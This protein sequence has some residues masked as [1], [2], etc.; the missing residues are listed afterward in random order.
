MSDN[1]ISLNKFISSTGFCSRRQAD[2]WI[3]SGRVRING[4]VAKK[5]NRVDIDDKV[6]I[7][8]EKIG[9]TKKGK[10]KKRVYI[11]LNK[12]KGITCTTDLKDKDNIISYIRHPKR[13][14]PIGRLDK[15]STGL[16]LLTNDGD[17][18]NKILRSENNHEKEYEVAVNKNVT[19]EFLTKMSSGVRIMGKRTKKCKV[20]KKGSKTFTITLTEG[21]N[22]QIRRMCNAFDYKVVSLNR[23]RVMNIKISN[24]RLGTWRDLTNEEVSTLMKM[25]SE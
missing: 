20:K 7:D 4:K 25:V 12:P 9:G 19:T 1:T 3:E 16:I 18:V 2:E 11:V 23:T 24:I 17:I 22:R 10:K 6:T 8:G 13:I 14:F 21:M 15:S 5:G